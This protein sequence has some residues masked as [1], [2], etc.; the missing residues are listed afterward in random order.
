MDGLH[1]LPNQQ[2]W[3]VE[4]SFHVYCIIHSVNSWFKTPLDIT[5][6]LA[7]KID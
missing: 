1:I 3:M 5:F 4:D 2:A 6:I 7:M